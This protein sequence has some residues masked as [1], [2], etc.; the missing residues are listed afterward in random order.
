MSRQNVPADM[1]E[2]V[3]QAAVGPD[4]PP[5]AGVIAQHLKVSRRTVNRILARR[6]VTHSSKADLPELTKLL[7]RELRFVPEDIPNAAKGAET[8]KLILRNLTAQTQYPA[9]LRGLYG[10]GHGR[11][12]ADS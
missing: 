12:G 3:R 4:G 7:S 1:L 11:D 2:Y 6:G 10:S 5:T 9:E 8:I